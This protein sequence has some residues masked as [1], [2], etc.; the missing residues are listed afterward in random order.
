M[1][2]IYIL[3]GLFGLVM[4]IMLTPQVI[5]DYFDEFRK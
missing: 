3:I 5:K 1:I 4:L 2:T